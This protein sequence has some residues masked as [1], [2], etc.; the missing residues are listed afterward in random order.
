MLE[1]TSLS[2]FAQLPP[3]L[4]LSSVLFCSPLPVLTFPG[5]KICNRELSLLLQLVPIQTSQAQKPPLLIQSLAAKAVDKDCPSVE[6]SSKAG[7][8]QDRGELCA[9]GKTSAQTVKWAL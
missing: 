5:L 2:S 4:A 3:A 7:P 1:F 9:S 6:T 8:G